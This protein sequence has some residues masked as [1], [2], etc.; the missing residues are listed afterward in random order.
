M[1]IPSRRI[2]AERGRRR[3]SLV[4]SKRYAEE[5]MWTIVP[6]RG[7]DNLQIELRRPEGRSKTQKL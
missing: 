7:R 4:W 5:T 6:A 1:P 2:D 3:S